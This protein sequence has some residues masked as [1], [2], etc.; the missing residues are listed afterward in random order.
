MTLEAIQTL[1]VA[2]GVTMRGGFFGLNRPT[3]VAIGVAI[4]ILPTAV[5]AGIAHNSY[6]SQWSCWLNLGDKVVFATLA[7]VAVITLVAII[8]TEAASMGYFTRLPGASP[9]Q[10]SAALANGKGLLVLLPLNVATWLVGAQA[11]YAVN[12]SLYT[13]VFLLN[14]FLGG[15]IFLF[16]SLGNPKVPLP[17]PPP[18]PPQLLTPPGAP[19]VQRVVETVSG[20]FHTNISRP[21]RRSTGGAHRISAR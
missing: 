8:I 9:A 3:L 19:A 14:L 5:S 18:P 16:H 12:V 6:V 11:V 15:A 7:P 10:Y 2:T 20:H 1:C 4:P 21:H 13:S 17:P